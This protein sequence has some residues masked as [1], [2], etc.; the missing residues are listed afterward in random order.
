MKTMN[1]EC[2]KEYTTV[3]IGGHAK[4]LYIPQSVEELVSLMRELEHE[5][6]RVLSG[7]SN[8]LINDQKEF[9]NVILMTQ[10]D[11][12]I[13][14]EGNGRYYAGASVRLQKLINTVNA[15]G[16]GGIEYLFS[17]PALVGGA[18]VM[19]AGRGQTMNQNISDC[20][21]DVHY[22]ENGESKTIKKEDCGFRFRSS[23][24]KNSARIV[25][26]ATFQFQA[27][28]QQASTAAKK[29]RIAYCKKTQDN[30]G[31]NFGSLFHKKDAK[32][33]RLIRMLHPGYKN[34]MCFSKQTSNRL[35]NRGEGTY[36]QA[37]NLINRAQKYHKWIGKKA[38][39]E[40]I[41]WE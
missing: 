15:D 13:T 31:Y 2:L 19:N 30:S 14:H 9:A 6:W 3:K 33:M 25:T 41:I 27:M 21:V 38:E 20:I 12:S 39:C 22:I 32:I 23:M 37:M 1:N 11:P 18:I 36:Q 17:V 10:T 7:G 34:G 35:L 26:G 29:D 5:D 24:F 16:Y 8:L 4:T 28:N 40:V